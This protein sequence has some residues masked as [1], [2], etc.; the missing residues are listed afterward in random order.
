MQLREKRETRRLWR[1]MGAWEAVIARQRPSLENE[2]IL[3]AE[4]KGG[5]GASGRQKVRN[6]SRKY[7]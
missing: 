2:I 7:R 6:T 3:G 4:N 1:G 5:G